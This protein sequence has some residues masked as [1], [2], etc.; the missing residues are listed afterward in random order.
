MLLGGSRDTDN[1]ENYKNLNKTEKVLEYQF[2]APIKRIDFCINLRKLVVSFY[3]GSISVFEV[4]V[5]AEEQQEE[6]SDDEELE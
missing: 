6:E 2:A 5:E 4:S 3:G 1:N